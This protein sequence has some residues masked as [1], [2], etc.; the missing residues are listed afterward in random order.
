MKSFYPLFR[1]SLLLRH[2]V[3]VALALLMVFF[4][5][6]GFS[7]TVTSS[8]SGTVADNSG[9]S[10]PNAK[11]VLTNEGTKTSQSTT[12][13]GAGYFS[14]TAILPGT[15]TLTISAK[16][17][18][19]WAEKGITIYQQE[20]RSVTNI[21]LKVGAVTETV[22]VSAVESPVPLETGASSTTLNDA[23]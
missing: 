10:V 14:F 23:W 11:V 7:Q 4:V 3:T 15:Y 17:F 21:A 16:G 9:A 1:F 6:P 19:T 5:R 13:S 18:A 8:L 2:G 12:A 20:S 22:E